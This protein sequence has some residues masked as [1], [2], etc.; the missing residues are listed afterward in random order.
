MVAV[1]R[2][3]STVS[4]SRGSRVPVVRQS[5]Q[6][7]AQVRTTRTIQAGVQTEYEHTQSS[8]SASW[9]VNHNLGRRPASVAVLSVG[10]VEVNAAV[11]HISINQ[12][13]VEFAAPQVGSV[14]SS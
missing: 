14:R 8:P 13:I 5:I 11:T 9:T 3:R 10:G 4:V 6:R 1:T 2:T 7:V 12:L